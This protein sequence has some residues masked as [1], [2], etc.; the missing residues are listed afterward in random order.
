MFIP[1]IYIPTNMSAYYVYYVRIL[2]D[3]T[4]FCMYM[5]FVVWK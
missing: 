1:V 3:K 4:A 2:K 5:T